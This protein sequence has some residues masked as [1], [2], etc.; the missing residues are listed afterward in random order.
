MTAA[1]FLKKYG[2]CSGV[3]LVRGRVVWSGQE[4]TNGREGGGVAKFRRGV[5]SQNAARLLGDFV[6]AHDLGWVAINDTFVPV[7]PDTVRGADVLYVS[8]ARVPK[9]EPPEDLTVPPELVIEVRSPTDRW[10]ELMTK[11]LEYL[12]AGVGVVVILDPKTRSASVYR[13]EDRQ[14]I[15]ESTDEL[16][17]PDVLPGFAVPVARFFG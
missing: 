10:T 2:H 16:K 14:D 17:L 9:G 6:R 8:Y 4:V 13:D 12:A 15:F 1:E 3:E 11:M 7:G 5:I